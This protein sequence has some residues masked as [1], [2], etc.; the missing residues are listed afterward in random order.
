MTTAARTELVTIIHTLGRWCAV[1]DRGAR[2]DDVTFAT[3]PEAIDAQ[4]HGIY[5]TH[6]GFIEMVPIASDD[7]EVVEVP[8][9]DEEMDDLSS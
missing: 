5:A 6:P 4:F 2:I 1:D 8:V 3:W 7:D 9:S